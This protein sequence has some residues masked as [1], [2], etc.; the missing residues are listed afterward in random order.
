[1]PLDD[2]RDEGRE[3]LR[4]GALDPAYVSDSL[5]DPRLLALYDSVVFSLRVLAEDEEVVICVVEE[6]IW[7]EDFAS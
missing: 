4:E 3:P 6:D 5:R 7:N 2:G 1:V